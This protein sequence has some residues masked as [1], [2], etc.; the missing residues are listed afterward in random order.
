MR[1]LFAVGPLAVL[2]PPILLTQVVGPDPEDVARGAQVFELVCAGCHSLDPPPDSAPPMR[3]VSAHLRRE[4]DTFE[5]FAE[6]VRTYVPAP[7][8]EASLLP[9]RALERFGLMDALPLTEDVLTAA[10]AYIWTLAD[11]A[12][13]MGPGAM[14]GGG[15]GMGPPGGGRRGPMRGTMPPDTT[16]TPDPGGQSGPR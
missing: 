15:H 1:A 4:L 13:V 5:A 16:G 9:P 7:S 3:H 14:R 12:V 8:A 6:H 10:A 11:S 2:L